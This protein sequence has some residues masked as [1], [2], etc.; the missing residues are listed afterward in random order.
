MLDYLM[1][2]FLYIAICLIILISVL[3]ACEQ[4]N[5]P[6]YTHYYKIYRQNQ[7]GTLTEW[8]VHKQIEMDG[9]F[10]KWEQEQGLQFCISGVITVV[11][12]IIENQQ[13]QDTTTKQQN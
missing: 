3:C 13:L 10:V 5:E 12:V 1:R 8:E 4:Q 6:K 2:P 11:P 9:A 7:D